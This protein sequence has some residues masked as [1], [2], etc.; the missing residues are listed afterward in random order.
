MLYR[1]IVFIFFIGLYSASAAVQDGCQVMVI[2]SNTKA[3]ILDISIDSITTSQKQIN[4]KYI[5][6]KENMMTKIKE[7]IIGQGIFQVTHSK[8]NALPYFKYI[9]KI[10]RKV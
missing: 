6:I 1:L 7:L 10:T 2:E 9:D 4:E 5:E 8:Q 3:I